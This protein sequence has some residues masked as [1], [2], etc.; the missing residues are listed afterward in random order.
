M[1][2]QSEEIP[3]PQDSQNRPVAT[4]VNALDGRIAGCTDQLHY[5]VEKSGMNVTQYSE[6]ASSATTSGCN[7][8]VTVPTMS[9]IIDRVIYLRTQLTFRVT[10]NAGA[11]NNIL[12]NGDVTVAPFPFHHLCASVQATIN[13]QSF[14]FD[15]LQALPMV[16]RMLDKDVLDEYASM[17]PTQQDYYGTYSTIPADTINSPFNDLTNYLSL[18]QIPRKAYIVDSGLTDGQ[19]SATV[20]LDVVEPLLLSPYLLSNLGSNSAGI[21][22]VNSLK[23]LFQFKAGANRALRFKALDD[24]G[25]PY[26]VALAGIATDTF[27]DFTFLTPHPSQAKSLVS[28]NIVPYMD[29]NVQK[30][31]IGKDIADGASADVTSNNFQLSLIPDKVMICVRKVMENQTSN[32][33]DACLPINSVQINFA[34]RNGLLAGAQKHQLFEMTR[35]AGVQTSWP[36][37]KGSALANG[38]NVRTSG[39]FLCLQF[40]RD[41]A[42][43]EDYFA[44]GSLGQF[45]FYVTANVT[46]NSSAGITAGQYELVLMFMNSGMLINEL[47]SSSLAVGLLTKDVVIETANQPPVNVAEYNR[48]Y[49]AGWWGSVK[50]AFRKAKKWVKPI[51]KATKVAAG[52]IP[53]PYAQG[54]SKGLEALGAGRS[55]G[56]YS[57]G[58]LRDRLM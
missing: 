38:N 4:Y 21:Y 54:L 17:C 37:F 39:S 50:S 10:G 46:N 33:A 22:G 25:T 6:R 19:T 28:R 15:C 13:N 58:S 56:G 51:A 5:A 27:L 30:T 9:T 3:V 23:F 1:S 18:G 8:T 2:E 26:V 53:H 43:S 14:S 32:D 12:A 41:I 24:N 35:N 31:I 16:M 40:G 45:S 52:L 57:G 55:G 34:N 47:G 29:I 42:I 7:F 49:G 36:E 44:S 11:G 20:V 48:M